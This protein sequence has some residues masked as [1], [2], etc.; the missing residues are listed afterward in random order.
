MDDTIFVKLGKYWYKGTDKKHPYEKHSCDLCG[1]EHFAR[2]DQPGKF[3]SVKCAQTRENNTRW[4]GEDAG[5]VSK[6]ARVYRVFGKA[7]TCV[8]GCVGKTRY[9]WANLND[10]N[11]NVGEFGVASMCSE[12]HSRYDASIR[13]WEIKVCKRGGHMLTNDTMYVKTRNGKEVRQCKQCAKDRARARNQKKG[14]Q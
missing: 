10:D 14:G 4:K 8:F 1:K 11:E 6:H 12:C 2:R 7:A 5:Y 3:C 9:E 13:K